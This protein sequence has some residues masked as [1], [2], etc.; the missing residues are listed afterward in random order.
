MATVKNRAPG[1]SPSR[2]RGNRYHLALAAVFVACGASL[3]VLARNREALL[4]HAGFRRFLKSYN[5]FTRRISG[6]RGS[7][8]GLL[9]HVGRRSGRSYQASLGVTRYGD[10]FLVPLTYGPGTDWYRNLV[11]AGCGTLAWQGRTHH[12]ERPELVSGPKPM[13]AWPLASRIMLLLL[14]VHAFVWLHEV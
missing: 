4:A 10:G 7:T 3:R 5:A 13:R 11:A 8:L 9:T 14:D 6:A 1:D 2:Q 12:V